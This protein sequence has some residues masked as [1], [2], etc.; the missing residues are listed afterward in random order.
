[1]Y[2]KRIAVA[3]LRHHGV[4]INTVSPGP[5]ETPLLPDFVQSIGAA[6]LDHAKNTVGR[7][8]TVEDI[9]PVIGFLASPQAR[10]INAQDI[11]VDGGY[12]GSMRA[13]QPISL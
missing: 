10:W 1:V 6:A 12:I 4:R 11:Q 9:A 8:A 13:G 5:V 2:V 7:H 3:A